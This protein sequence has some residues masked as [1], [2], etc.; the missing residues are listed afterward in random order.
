[1][2]IAHVQSATLIGIE[3]LPIVI[4]VD[5]RG[6]TGEFIMVGL[7]DKAVDES[8]VRVTTAIRNSDLDWPKKQVTSPTW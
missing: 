3:A 4:E 8:K 1:M 5:L 7:P 2:A 6:G